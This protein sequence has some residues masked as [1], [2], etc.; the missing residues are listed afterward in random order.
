[1][2][3]TFLGIPLIAL[4]LYMDQLIPNTEIIVIMISILIKITNSPMHPKAVIFVD[5]SSD[6][7][8]WIM[9]RSQ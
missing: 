3:M 6:Q 2:M 4:N 1:M 8:P 5:I 9:R 7:Y